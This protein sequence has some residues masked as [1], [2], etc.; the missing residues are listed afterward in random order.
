[1]SPQDRRETDPSRRQIGYF[2]HLRL[3]DKHM[4]AILV[5]N[6]IGVP[7]EFKYTEPVSTTR[8]QKIL[9]GAVLDRYLHE[10]VLRDRLAQETRTPADFYITPYEDKEFLSSLAGVEMIAVQRHLAAQGEGS[11]PFTRLRER[12]VLIEL[13]DGPAFRVV[14]ATADDAVQ[15]RIA[16]ALQ[17]IGRTMDIVEPLERMAAALKTLCDERKS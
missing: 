3:G 1:M 13:E 10:T 14:F 7:L 15:H 11:G 8:L 2:C 12:E 5:T 16:T 6:Q 4:G 17:E 9:Y